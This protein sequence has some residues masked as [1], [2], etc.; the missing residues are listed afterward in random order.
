M[1]ARLAA[2]AAVL[3]TGCFHTDAVLTVHADGSATLD[4]TVAVDGILGLGAR[5]SMQE[6]GRP[7]VEGARRVSFQATSTDGALVIQTRY[8][9]DD[10]AALRY[11]IW[12]AADVVT[13]V[14]SL[15]SWSRGQDAMPPAPSSVLRFALTDGALH[16]T[17]PERTVRAADLTR[18]P[19]HTDA[20]YT[21]AQQAEVDAYLAAMEPGERAAYQAALDARP[22]YNSGRALAAGGDASVRLTVV[23]GTDSTRLVDA[24]FADLAPDAVADGAAFDAA[25]RTTGFTG[26]G[27][28]VPPPGEITLTMP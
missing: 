13:T 22:L 24:R 2:L 20:D 18:L 7:E 5:L 21:P 12:D 8:A 4:E 17:V 27:R 26:P 25:A 3:L 15:A 9:V 1:T 23:A 19:W 28:R 11:D 14:R 16:V 6:R 10:V